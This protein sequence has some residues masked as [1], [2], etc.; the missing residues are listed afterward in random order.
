MNAPSTPPHP[1]LPLITRSNVLPAIIMAYVVFNAI[2]LGSAGAALRAPRVLMPTAIDLAVPFVP[3]TIWIYLSQ[4]LLVPWALVSERDDATR[5]RAF[6]AMLLAA[7]LS[8]VV[9]VIFP[10]RV[11]HPATPT[12]GLS[13]LAWHLLRMLDTP[14]NAFP[15]LHVALATLAGVAL[16]RGRRRLIAAIWPGCI[17][18]S[19]LTTRQHVSWDVAGGLVAAAI[20]W[21]LAP[22]FKSGKNCVDGP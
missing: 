10:T 12:G 6:Y 13:G 19:T 5:S 8:C 9:F 16:W 17:V 3:W 4:F 20:A 18:L 1:R 15:S 14:D 22:K 7:L 21:F 11:P 2:Y